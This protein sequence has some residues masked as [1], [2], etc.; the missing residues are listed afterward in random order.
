MRWALYGCMEKGKRAL[1]MHKVSC[2]GWLAGFD[3]SSAH[4][5]FRAPAHMSTFINFD[6]TTTQLLETKRAK[7]GNGGKRYCKEKEEE[8]KNEIKF[9]LKLVRA[10]AWCKLG[11]KRT[12]WKSLFAHFCLS[13]HITHTLFHPASHS[14]ESHLVWCRCLATA[15]SFGAVGFEYVCLPKRTIQLGS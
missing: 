13:N 9:N 11:V 1:V 15:V 2:A 8:G 5:H 12:K 14:L 10:Q 3:I 6:S 7:Q 4:H